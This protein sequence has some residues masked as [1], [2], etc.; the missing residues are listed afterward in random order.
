MCHRRLGLAVPV[1]ATVVVFRTACS[2]QVQPT[3]MAVV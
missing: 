2:C 3:V 1:V